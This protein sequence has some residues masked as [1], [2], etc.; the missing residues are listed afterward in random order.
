MVNAP[1]GLS[2]VVVGLGFGSDF[3]PVYLSHPDVARV[4]ICDPDAGRLDTVGEQYGLHDRFETLEDVLGDD[5]WDAVHLLSPVAFHADQVAQVLRA[6][7]HCAC[8]V[9]MATSLADI[10]RLIAAQR[11]SGRNYMMMETAVYGREYFYARHLRDSGALGPLTFLRGYHIQDLHGFPSYWW[12]FPPMYYVTH[13]LS[14][15]LALA[16]TRAVTVRCLGSGRLREDLVHD[17]DNPFPLETAQFQLADGGLAAEVTM[18]FHH[19]GRAYQEGFSVYGH[20]GGF[21]WEQVE[22]EGPLRFSMGPQEAGRRGRAAESRRVDLPDFGA[23]LPQ[24]IRRFTRPTTF[25]PGHGTPF[26]VGAHHGG[27]HPHLVHEFVRSIV[28]G[29]TPAVDALT[30]A[31]WTAP[32]VCAHESAMRGGEAVEIPDFTSGTTGE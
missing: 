32:G 26:E 24:E 28:E 23:R 27:S 31:A 22:G 15:L 4:G 10:H 12:G 18:A 30:A 7:K 29:R 21:E 17:Y 2:V 3:L 20:D 11:A 9:P 5:R 6:G 19:T 14:P 16:D 8:A 13:A 1:E 25:D